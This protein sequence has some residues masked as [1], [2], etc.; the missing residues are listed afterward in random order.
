M[1]QIIFIVVVV[2]LFSSC[3]K[4]EVEKQEQP[5]PK[6]QPKVTA[7]IKSIKHGTSFGM[8]VGY[9]HKEYTYTSGKV[10]YQASGRNRKTLT[11]TETLTTDNWKLFQ[12]LINMEAFFKLSK[13]IGCPDCADGG[14]EWIEIET[15]S[16]KKHK[17][18]FDFWKAPDQLKDLVS[19]LRQFEWEWEVKR[20]GSK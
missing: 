9:C 7:G 1:K 2:A 11:Y 18:T 10:V 20:N 17:V 12:S 3:K 13:T 4:E 8:C 15:I 14:A 16:G 19:V 6:E 5:Q